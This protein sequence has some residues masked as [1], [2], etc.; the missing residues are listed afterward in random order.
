MVWYS[1]FYRDSYSRKLLNSKKFRKLVIAAQTDDD[2]ENSLSSI[3]DGL[4]S[5]NYKDYLI[6][7]LRSQ[8]ESDLSILNNVLQ[9][10]AQIQQSVEEHQDYKRKLTAFKERNSIKF[11][12]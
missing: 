1:Q 6:K 7:Q 9:S 3:I 5:I 2:G 4:E 11:E 8:I 12:D 10:L